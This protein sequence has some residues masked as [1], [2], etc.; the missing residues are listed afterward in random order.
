MCSN[1][2]A[3]D[4]FSESRRLGKEDLSCHW[5]R[6]KRKRQT[7]WLLLLCVLIFF[8]LIPT[9]STTTASFIQFTQ[10]SYNAS[11]PEESMGKVYVTPQTRMGI[12]SNDSSLHIRYRIKSGDPDG[13]FKAEA[14]RVGDFVFLLIRTKTSNP[15]VLNRERTG[16]YNLEVRARVKSANSFV[17]SRSR[18]S[19]DPKTM[20]RVTIADTNDLSP[21]FQQPLYSFKVAEDTPVHASVGLV[22][23][24]DA[25]EGVLIESW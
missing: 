21:F 24:D 11:I 13:F 19:K 6:R 5:R 2:S 22:K 1:S 23:A 7:S 14:E 17:G 15:N 10:P 9:S 18:K 20:V 25:D 3:K 8:T 12:Q 16:S 4:Q